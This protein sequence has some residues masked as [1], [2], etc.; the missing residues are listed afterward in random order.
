MSQ[1]Y[2]F[3]YIAYDGDCPMCNNYVHYVRLREEYD[4][5]M[6]NLRDDDALRLSLEQKGY[7]LNKGMIVQYQ[8]EEYYGSEAVRIMAELSENKGFIHS[9]NKKFF[10]SSKRSATLYPWL[11]RGRSALL[12]I[13][14]RE[15]FPSP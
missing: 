10:S 13:L 11:A 5:R 12:K 6:I 1:I 3:N 14:G 2:D 8:N 15:K 9:L 4:F 7:D